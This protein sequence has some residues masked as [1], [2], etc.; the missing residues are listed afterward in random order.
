[1][2]R[3]G[4]LISCVLLFII[5]VI[6][7]LHTLNY[8]FQFDDR[9]NIVENRAVQNRSLDK[10]GL[11]NLFQSQ[12]ASARNRPVTNISFNLNFLVGELEP[13]GY[14]AFNILIHGLN[15]IL[16]FLLFSSVLSALGFSTDRARVPAIFASALWGLNPLHTESV[17]YIVQR[18]TSMSATFFLL[19]CLIFLAARENVQSKEMTRVASIVLLFFLSFLSKENGVLLPF[20]LLLLAFT[21]IS[22]GSLFRRRALFILLLTGWFLLIAGAIAMLPSDVF[23]YR[24]GDGAGYGPWERV[25]TQ[26]LVLFW[27]VSL[28][29]LPFPSR[30]NIDIHFPASAGLLSPPATLVAI[31]IWMALLFAA[32]RYR[33]SNPLFFLGLLWYLILNSL[34]SSFLPLEMAFLHRTYLPSLFIFLQFAVLISRLF[35]KGDIRRG[36]SGTS[37]NLIAL[38]VGLAIA[39][40]VLT[41]KRNVVY[42]SAISLWSD[43]TFKSPD[44]A[45]PHYNLGREMQE[46]GNYNKAEKLYFKALEI[47]PDYNLP[48]ASLAYIYEQQGDSERAFELYKRSYEAKKNGQVAYNLG[49]LYFNVGEISTARVFLL[50]SLDSKRLTQRGDAWWYLAI[51][52]EQEGDRGKAL[53]HWKAALN[54]YGEDSDRGRQVMQRIQM[55]E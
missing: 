40:A 36:H 15:T 28:L 39:S 41:Y 43:A 3:K 53:A 49:R 9:T 10:D 33:H 48:L 11:K 4:V 12:P 50:E 7:Y 17:T 14:R 25:I 22:P 16:A 47:R 32:W 29:F 18:A 38:A 44:K 37:R 26:P 27:Y 31:L 34:E 20:A 1:M 19:A 6:P 55:F 54:E 52:E 8:P 51:I 5:I 42:A 30:L 46:A 35:E 23:N 13:A 45:R 2:D 24:V 21:C